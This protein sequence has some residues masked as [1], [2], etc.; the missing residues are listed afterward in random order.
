MIGT[1]ARA[2]PAQ[3]LEG[4]LEKRHAKLALSGNMN[5]QQFL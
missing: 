1:Y 4:M 2:K 3:S 5:A